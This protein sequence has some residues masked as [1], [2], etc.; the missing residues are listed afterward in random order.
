M[1]NTER[2]QLQEEGELLQVNLLL[3]LLLLREYSCGEE[4]TDILKTYLKDNRTATLP[5]NVIIK[6]ENNRV[7][8]LLQDTTLKPTE[9]H[10]TSEASG[11]PQ[12]SDEKN[13]CNSFRTPD[14]DDSGLDSQGT[15]LNHSQSFII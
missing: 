7:N 4:S 15:M 11:H 14:R 12:P 1:V 5:R 8:C 6:D 2:I 9:F 10:F 13:P 3:A